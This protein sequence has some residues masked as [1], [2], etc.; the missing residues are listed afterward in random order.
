MPSPLLNAWT[1]AVR[2]WSGV[3]APP[4]ASSLGLLRPGGPAP[5]HPWGPEAAAALVVPAALAPYLDHTLLRPDATEEEVEALAAEAR[6]H[7][8]GGACVHAVHVA[9]LVQALGDSAVEP[10]SVVGFPHG[11]HL[12]EIKLL[13]ARRAADEGAAVVDVVASLGRLKAGEVDRVLGELRA[14]VSALAPVPVRV[15]LETGLLPAKAVVLGAGIALA[16]GCDAVKT[17]TGFNGPGARP[18]DVALLRAVVGSQLGVKASGGIRTAQ[19][20]RAL[21]AAGASR[22]GASSSV[23]LITRS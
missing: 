16:A 20:A 10:V 9:A 3:G 7:G 14:L 23:G 8:F 18:E 21:V 6:T 15:I 13:E 17:S 1:E 19:Q 12:A 11:A 2:A 22:L 4:S 5:Q